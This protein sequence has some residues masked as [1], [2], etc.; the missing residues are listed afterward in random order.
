MRMVGNCGDKQLAHTQYC[1]YCGRCD[2]DC[3]QRKFYSAVYSD[4]LACLD[5]CCKMGVAVLSDTSEQLDA[6]EIGKRVERF[7][8]DYGIWT[9][10]KN[11]DLE[12]ISHIAYVLG[13]RI[14]PTVTDNKK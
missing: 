12:L 7:A 8:R 2:E 1:D 14:E 9:K 5:C 11:H 6:T 3:P 10:V 13:L 4:A